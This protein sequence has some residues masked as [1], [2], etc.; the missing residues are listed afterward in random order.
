MSKGEY[1]GISVG[2]SLHGRWVDR[3]DAGGP[4]NSIEGRRFFGGRLDDTL[5]SGS[6]AAGEVCAVGQVFFNTAA[7]SGQNVYCMHC[8]EYLDPGHDAKERPFHER[9]RCAC[10]NLH[11]RAGFIRRH[12]EPGYVA[13]R[14]F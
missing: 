12:P 9:R 4:A 14:D 1:E 3:A 2:V 5:E 13:L 6:G 8:A 10:R 11:G 7:P